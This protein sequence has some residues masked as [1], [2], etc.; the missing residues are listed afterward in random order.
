M[1][2]KHIDPKTGNTIANNQRG[3]T[4]S[5]IPIK[6]F[7]NDNLKKKIYKIYKKYFE[8]FEKHG[9]IYNI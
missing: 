8:I 2:T 4:E 6:D 7:F 3:N 5:S 1:Y 9:F